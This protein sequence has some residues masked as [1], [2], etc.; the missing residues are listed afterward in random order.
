[1][2]VFYP[3]EARRWELARAV[4]TAFSRAGGPPLSP[5]FEWEEVDLTLTLGRPGL[6]AEERAEWLRKVRRGDYDLVLVFSSWRSWS[7]AV[8]SNPHGPKP[9]RSRRFPAGF[10]WLQGKGLQQAREGNVQ[11]D[12]AVELLLAARAARLAAEREEEKV[13]RRPTEF[14]WQFPEDL[15]GLPA[16][17]PGS[18]WALSKVRA[19]GRLD[20]VYTQAYRNCEFEV[21]ADPRPARLLTDVEEF[22]NLGARGWPE[23]SPDGLYLG[24][25]EERCG[26]FHDRSR[27]V[28]LTQGERDRSGA[29]SVGVVAY[30]GECLAEWAATKRAEP[31]PQRLR[32]KV[33]LEPRP[34]GG[35][36]VTRLA[37]KRRPALATEL[38]AL[39]EGESDDSASDP[40]AE[41]PGGQRLGDGWWGRGPPMMARRGRRKRPVQT[42][43]GFCSPGRWAPAARRL[44][45]GP[46]AREMQDALE[47]AILAWEEMAGGPQQLR[48]RYFEIVSGDLEESPVPPEVQAVFDAA[49]DATIRRHG[50]DPA[51]RSGDR[52][53]QFLVRRMEAA[54]TLMGDP[55]AAVL[56]TDYAKGVRVGVGVRMPRARAVF[57]R[58][59]K[60]KLPEETEEEAV[61]WKENYSSAREHPEILA[62]QLEKD[63]K[64]R[65]P[66]IILMERR[67][68]ERRW[69]GRLFVG[70]LAVIEEAPGK[71][72]IVHDA[73]HEV[74]VNHRIRVRDQL[75][76]PLA[77]DMQAT[78][79]EMLADGRSHYGLVVDVEGAHRTVVVAEED[80]GYQVSSPFA[81]RPPGDP[82]ERLAVNPCGTFGLGSAAYWWGRLGAHLE[83]WLHYVLG[84]RYREFF[85]A[86]FADDK[87]L[88]A[89]GPHWVR[90]LLMCLVALAA[91]G[92]QLK[93]TKVGGG[94]VYEWIGYAEDLTRFALGISV[95]RRDWLL[96]W[97]GD[98]LELGAVLVQEMQEVVG[99]FGFAYQVL[100]YDRPFL[101]PIYAW[102]AAVPPGSCLEVP[103]MLKLVLR[104][105]ARRLRERHMIPALERGEEGDDELFRAD[106]RATDEVASVGGW[107]CAGGKTPGEAR[108]FAVE[109]N[110]DNALWVFESKTPQRK[111]AALELF[112]T[113]LCVMLFLPERP[114]REAGRLLMSGGTDNEGNG[115]LLDRLM[116]AKYPL[117]CVLM[118]L[119]AALEDRGARLRLEWV[120]RERNEPADALSNLEFGQ[121]DPRLRIP[122]NLAKLPFRVLPEL[123]AAGKDLFEEIAAVKEEREQHLWRKRS[124]NNGRAPA[125]EERRKRLKE[126]DPW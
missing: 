92:A 18:P 125:K 35:V 25:L 87:R 70:A 93:W 121:F 8:Y 94:Q 77:M 66:R 37:T 46:A 49:L 55:D 32:E 113:L 119:A 81:D 48:A 123:L 4:E 82:E 106:A 7:R 96:K 102:V 95:K 124:S 122:V 112:A 111:I 12:F 54:L 105:L 56:G 67:E 10:P 24:P 71:W 2:I 76:C 22:K 63:E 110:V 41:D 74:L 80:W 14:L 78:Q 60:W 101:A 44:P 83:R 30:F 11:I 39:Q 116:T 58:K 99:R 61:E 34:R 73:T 65:P 27:W 75:A 29:W 28:G 107:E 17:D 53:Q 26:H 79:E 114:L 64:A 3:G 5:W 15:G 52:E 9:V 43:G 88:V 16:G 62:A 23:I 89:R 59:T 57:G 42:G 31:V 104:W 68:A 98:T 13:S 118:E 103:A 33:R 108:W 36:T 21:P 115:Y 40:E 47:A 120:P 91:F 45:D 109:L 72:R 97:I 6:G 1:M 100:E 69:P 84:R 50:A 86:L 126:R 85:S 19:L 90:I 38:R 20:R 117:C 51:P